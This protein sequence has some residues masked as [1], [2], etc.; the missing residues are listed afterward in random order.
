MTPEGAKWVTDKSITL[1]GIDYCSI[2]AFGEKGNQTH[3]TLLESGVV[4]LE[5]LDL[6]QVE[7][8]Q[9]DIICLPLKLGKTE[10]APTRVV[11]LESRSIA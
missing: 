6:R 7:A 3:K 8:G 1:V 9:Y 10:G 5:G 11:L 4:I 2:E